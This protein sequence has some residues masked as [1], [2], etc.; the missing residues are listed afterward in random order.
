VGLQICQLFSQ[1][2]AETPAC[3]CPELHLFQGLHCF[4]PNRLQ[5]GTDGAGDAPGRPVCEVVVGLSRQLCNGGEGWQ[6]PTKAHRAEENCAFSPSPTLASFFLHQWKATER[7]RLVHSK[8]VTTTLHR[9]IAT[10]YPRPYQLQRF[11]MHSE[12]VPLNSKLRTHRSSVALQ[13]DPRT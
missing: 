11:Q 8:L 6:V 9:H 1:R 2:V 10:F 3:C 4:P 12:T 13:T 7:K 5:A